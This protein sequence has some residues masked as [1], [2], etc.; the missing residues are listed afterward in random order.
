M[1]LRIGDKGDMVFIGL[2]TQMMGKTTS[3]LRGPIA[4]SLPLSILPMLSLSSHK[5]RT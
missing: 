4:E 5:V 2:R 1:G 3:S